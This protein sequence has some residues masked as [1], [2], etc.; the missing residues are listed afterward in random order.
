[1]KAKLNNRYYYFLINKELYKKLKFQVHANNT[2]HQKGKYHI[3]LDI[4]AYFIHLICH[5]SLQRKDK[6]KNGYVNL[7]AEYLKKYHANYTVYFKFLEKIELVESTRSYRPKHYSKGYRIKHELDCSDFDCYEVK[8]FSFRK[9]L[10]KLN[11]KR[12]QTAD[13]TTYHLTKWLNIDHLSIDYDNA[14]QY[15]KNY[16]GLPK[17]KQIRK[18]AVE[19]I[20]TGLIDYSREGRDNRLHSILTHLPK[21]MRKFIKTSNNE[22]LMALDIKSSQPYLFAALLK[23]I[24][25]DKDLIKIEGLYKLIKDKNIRQR[26]SSI[27]SIMIHKN[28]EYT[29]ILEISEFINL[30][31]T[32]DI[33]NYISSNFTEKLKYEIETPIGIGDY[34]YCKNVKKNKYKHFDNLRDYSKAIMLEYLY[35]SPSKKR[36]RRQKEI[37]NMFPALVNEIIDLFKSKYKEDFAILLQNIEAGLILDII[38]KNIS[39]ID[40]NIQLYT[41]HDS[42]VTL[43]KHEEIVLSEI[44][45]IYLNFFD[46]LPKIK[47]EVWV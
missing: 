19:I 34:F 42:I 47:S 25:I 40:K 26:V 35:C 38:T 30:V 33:Y 28:L 39:L 2:I 37:R 27:I 16:K 14:I 10:T 22:E 31:E 18:F 23:L 7:K 9:K 4:A 3:K 1:M 6:L 5:K 8:D 13:K 46:W 24:F 12:M 15:L 21:D 36:K 17:Q 41:I 29:D 20:R 43:S 11:L 32:K 44:K 45:N